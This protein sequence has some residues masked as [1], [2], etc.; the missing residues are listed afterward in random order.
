MALLIIIIGYILLDKTYLGFL[1]DFSAPFKRN[2]RI[3][4]LMSEFA[5]N[6]ANA[7]AAQELGILYFEKKN[8]RK[9]LE[10][11][12]KAN[13]K[14]K[15]SAELYLF[16]GM[17][18]TE[19][20]QPEKGKESIEK[21]LELDRKIGRGLPYVYLRRLELNHPGGP[22]N[23]RIDEEFKNFANAENFYRMGVV[24]KKAGLGREAAEMFR[25]ALEEYKYVPK[26]LRR[27][28][29][30]WALLSRLRLSLG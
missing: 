4:S 26:T 24:Y 17:A 15:N 2:A 3:R 16:A 20:G 8:Y 30:K 27:I 12:E 9:A 18:Y 28:H 29:R 23:L 19:L 7:S 10:Y 21:A 11:L 22:E 6:P 5:V 13:E 25:H 1:P 14:V